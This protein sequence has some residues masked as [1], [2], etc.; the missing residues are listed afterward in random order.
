MTNVFDKYSSTFSGVWSL[1]TY[2]MYDSEGPDRN[3]LYKPHGDTPL[4]KVVISQSG[5]LSAILI[6]PAVLTPLPSDYLMKASDEALA[7]I[8]RPLS[9]YSGFMT[10]NETDDQ[11]KFVWHTKV[12]VS[13]NPNWI[14]KEQT[15]RVEYFEDGGDKYMTLNPVRDYPLPDGR[16]ARAELKWKKIA[17]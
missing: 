4:G 2:E 7:R 14:G 16:M 6:P 9:A 13:A 12:E 10:L 8:A 3:L 11:G 5:Y 1:L 15:R 17:S